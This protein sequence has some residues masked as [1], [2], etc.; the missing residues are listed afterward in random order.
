MELSGPPPAAAASNVSNFLS[1]LRLALGSEISPSNRPNEYF[2][3]IQ[4][5]IRRSIKEFANFRAAL[6]NSFERHADSRASFDRILFLL[7]S[8]ASK[9]DR[10]DNLKRIRSDWRYNSARLVK[11]F[12]VE[13]R[14][15]PNSSEISLLFDRIISFFSSFPVDF[16]VEP[17]I[18]SEGGKVLTFT[19]SLRSCLEFNLVIE[20][21]SNF[22]FD[23][24]N[25]IFH[26]FS[27][28]TA[29]FNPEFSGSEIDREI[30]HLLATDRM[31]E[32]RSNFDFL[33]NFQ[34]N[35]DE[36][37][38]R[39]YQNLWSQVEQKFFDFSSAVKSTKIFRSMNGPTIEIFS[40]FPIFRSSLRFLDVE[41]PEETT[42]FLILF[43]CEPPL[44]IDRTT[45]INLINFIEHRK[46]HTQSST[47]PSPS[48][49]QS[50]SHSLSQSTR[51]SLVDSSVAFLSSI[52]FFNS[53][54]LELF[55][56]YCR[57]SLFSRSLQLF[58]HLIEPNSIERSSISNFIFHP[59]NSS[60]SKINIRLSFIPSSSFPLSVHIS[61]SD[62][63][64]SDFT[65]SVQSICE[66]FKEINEIDEETKKNFQ[67]LIERKLN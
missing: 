55:L 2:S 44:E 59:R 37:P 39:N 7:P 57:V 41:R 49:S 1:S 17:S 15:S 23:S 19:N 4:P 45:A 53:F 8:I 60:Q 22:L 28:V 16:S 43:R 18:S 56:E 12:L 25:S 38:D 47:S 54:T 50:H 3:E 33:L 48:P 24:S 58:S 40:N 27:S 52:R 62:L 46:S 14:E 67:R 51:T 9:R 21:N 11:K 36:F 35:C 30:F 5:T 42:K 66:K 63:A 26:P 31:E 65:A 20:I 13:R 6:K 32:F 29:E 61:R 34:R 64:E 10:S